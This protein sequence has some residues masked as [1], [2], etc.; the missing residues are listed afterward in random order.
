MSVSIGNYSPNNC[1]FFASNSACVIVPL[2]SKALYFFNSS[3]GLWGISC[4]ITADFS[5]RPIKSLLISSCSSSRFFRKTNLIAP[6][7]S[8][9][10]QATEQAGSNSSNRIQRQV[11]TV[12]CCVT[13]I[14]SF[15]GDSNLNLIRL[16]IRFFYPKGHGSVF[17]EGKIFQ[18]KPFCKHQSLIFICIRTVH[19]NL[20]VSLV[21]YVVRLWGS[22]CSTPAATGRQGEVHSR[23]EH[24]R[25]YL[26]NC[27][28]KPTAVLVVPKSFSYAQNKISERGEESLQ[29]R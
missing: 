26:F 5:C 24:E 1:F 13:S 17:V 23:R 22:S 16:T 4:F 6:R 8:S 25:E 15:I 7:G 12:C 2:S 10:S 14:Y 18:T 21:V 27:K 19:R 28:R 9:Y 11:N 3:A 20:N 29:K